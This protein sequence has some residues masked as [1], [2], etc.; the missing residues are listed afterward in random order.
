M[1]V[2]GMKCIH[3]KERVEKG[4]RNVQGENDADVDLETKTVTI[5]ACDRINERNLITAVE[6]IGFGPVKIL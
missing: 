3:C 1:T 5:S 2:E 4:L 6:D